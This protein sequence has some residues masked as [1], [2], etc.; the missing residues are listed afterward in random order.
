MPHSPLI[1]AASATLILAATAALTAQPQESGEIT[2]E[3]VAAAARVI[4][5]EF[6]PDELELMLA[7]VREHTRDI[8]SVR[9]P[10]PNSELPVLVFN[11]LLPGMTPRARLKPAPASAESHDLDGSRVLRPEDLNELAFAPI[12]TWASLIRSRQVSCTEVTQFFLDRLV[13]LDEH[14]HCVISYTEERALNQAALLDDELAAGI[15]RGP[16]HGIPWG[17]KDLLSARGA[18]TTW[19]A[20][21]FADQVLDEDAAV[22]RRLEEAG[23]VLIAKLSVGALAWGDVWFGA[24]TLNPWDLSQGSSGSSA[25]SASATAAG[26][27]VF[28][29]GTETLGSIVS[30]SVRCRTSSL[31]PTFGRVPRTG[32]MALTWSMDKIGPICRSAADVQLVFAAIQG[33][34][35]EDPTVHDLPYDPNLTSDVRGWKVGYPE[36]SFEPESPVLAQLQGLGVELVE[37]EI[38]RSR[39][40]GG[41]LLTLGAEAAAAFDELTR[42][43]RDAQLV[44]QVK[45]AWPNVFRAARLIPAVEYVNAQ[46]LR[47]KLIRDFD[48]A[49]QGVEAIVHP[50]FSSGILSTTNLT[51]HPTFVAPGPSGDDG[52]G[53]ISFTGHLFDEERL[54]VLARAWQEASDYDDAHPSLEFLHD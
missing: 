30:P 44:R 43:G 31:R 28:A 16:L 17:A 27:V 18:P 4:G 21:P 22:V 52:S 26:G 15:W 13:R 36:G 45:D 48:G 46:R 2:L 8:D 37:L 29:L 54:L 14:L 20:R 49:L 32:C 12:S 42:S 33:P 51:G 34:D 1:L 6:E 47:S 53:S 10:L 39:A 7:D 35:G 50:S 41:M 3:D 25:G 23:A 24:T 40:T 9:Q 19:G 5:L 11:P 38:P